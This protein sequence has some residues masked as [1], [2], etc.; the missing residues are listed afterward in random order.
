MI[1]IIA[2]SNDFLKGCDLSYAFCGGYALELFLNK[3]LR[4][5]SDV[6]IVAFE[7]DKGPMIEYVS[8]KGWK[9]YEHKTEWIDNKKANSY[10]RL[11]QNSNDPEVLHLNSVWAMKP[12]CS[13]VKV[14]P[15]LGENNN[16]GYE[17]RNKEQLKS[18]FFEIIFSK[19][20]DGNFVVDS[21]AGQDKNIVRTLDKAIRY[22]GDIPY[23]A[24]EIVL[25]FTAHPA[26]LE[27]DYHREKN[28]IDWKY[29]PAFLPEESLRWLIDSLKVAY[30]EGNQ[31]LDELI[32]LNQ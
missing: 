5:H 19:Q 15:K 12:D 16:F 18:D 13:L 28:N 26:Y 4:S 31:R 27:S 2:E 29:T 30:P 3:T 1:K 7:K 8:S 22:H 23:L 21:L 20:K 9:V 10:L 25:F 6:D 11:V 17:I 14:G 32:A 24:P